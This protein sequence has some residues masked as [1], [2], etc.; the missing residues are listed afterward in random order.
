MAA[1]H[2]LYPQNKTYKLSNRYKAHSPNGLYYMTITVVGWIDVFTRKDNCEILLDSLRYC[3][4]NKGLTVYGYVIMPNH[5]HMVAWVNEPFQLTE[6][7]RDFKK[8]TARQ[9]LEAIE[10]QPE[11]RREW[12]LHQFAY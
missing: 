4:A 2:Q 5:L 10:T 3:Q 8:F 12:M 9:I 7:V 1:Q 11:S 6:V